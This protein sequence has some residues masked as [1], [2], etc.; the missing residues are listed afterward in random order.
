MFH[1]V[2]K[3]NTWKK[4][5]DILLH[6]CADFSAWKSQSDFQFGFV[7]LSNLVV[8]SN[9]GHIGGKVLDPI[10]QHFA[11]KAYGVPNFLG[12][13]IPI[14]SQLNVNEWEHELVDYWDQQLL[15]LIKFGF[16]LSFNRDC[17]LFTD[18]KNHSSAIEFPNDVQ[19][20]LDEEKQ[21]GAILGPFE[22]SPIPNLHISPFMTRDK[23]NAPNRRVIIDLSWPKNNSVNAGIDKNSYLRAEFSLT[24][25]TVD[26]ITHQLMLLGR[27][28]HIYKVDIS[29][30]FRH[31]KVDPLDYDLLGLNWD[32]TYLDTCIPFGSRHGSQ[33]FQRVSDAVRFALRCHGY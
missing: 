30:A 25:P 21:H 18:K 13:R 1:A 24:F 14:V 33:N 22:S 9:Q 10:A 5:D 32:G 8:S 4:F 20:Y 2:L 15:Q 26:D 28:A 23:P 16:P 7:P 29:R 12:A 27:G 11:V 6:N 31:L 19:T 3:K 17:K